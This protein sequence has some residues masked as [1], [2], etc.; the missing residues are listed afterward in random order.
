MA[1]GIGVN[2]L[3]LGYHKYAGFIAE[4]S[5]AVIGGDLTAEGII[6]PL[7]ISFF[8]FQQI[9][10]LV[11]SYKSG[12]SERSVLRHCLFVAF[13]PQLIAGPIV[14]H[15]EMLPQLISN[16][17]GNCFTRNLAIGGTIFVLGLGEK[18]IPADGLS[19]AADPIFAA[20]AKGETLTLLEAW[21]GAIAYTFQIYF[22]FSGYSDM[23]I[24]L[25][26]AFGIRL[27]NNFDSPYKAG[28][29]VDFWN[30][31]HITLSRFLRIYLYIPL[32]GNRKGEWRRYA[33]L[34][35]TMLLGGLWHGAGWTFVA[36]GALHASALIIER[37][38]FAVA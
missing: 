18:V 26:Y 38:L 15:R 1:V 20:A 2:L 34:M 29:I 31:W 35:V 9:A 23:A 27:P 8:T 22:D 37:T 14:H 19:D 6:F 16:R 13:S 4:N 33:N 10:Y 17:L 24:G 25:A 5:K 32:G 7:A 21:G 11:D 28:S 36:W 3:I 12:T 30:R